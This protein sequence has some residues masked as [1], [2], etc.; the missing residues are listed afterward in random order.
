MVAWL[1]AIGSALFA[2]HFIYG[3]DQEATLVLLDQWSV[4]IFIKLICLTSL[5]ALLLNQLATPQA[6]RKWSKLAAWLGMVAWLLAIG[7]ALFAL[8]LRYGLDQRATQIGRASGTH[9][10]ENS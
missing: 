4:G 7:S 6:W 8:C 9:R 3:L 1:L 10:L 2:L 5:L